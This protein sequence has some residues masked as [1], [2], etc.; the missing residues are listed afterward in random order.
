MKK[1]LNLL[2]ELKDQSGTTLIELLVSITILAM[3]VTTFLSV[4]LFAT[5]TNIDTNELTD[6]TRV[7]QTCMEEV[8]SSSKLDTVTNMTGMTTALSSYTSSVSGT[9]YTFTKQMD[10]YYVVIVFTK[11]AYPSISSTMYKVVVNTYYDAAH[12]HRAAKMQNII[13]ID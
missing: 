3:I 8:Y 11:N 10:G 7:A 9:N 5:R 6:G 12:T 13:I 2:Q 1:R 4:F